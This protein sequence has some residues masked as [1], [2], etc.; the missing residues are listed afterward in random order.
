MSNGRQSLKKLSFMRQEGRKPFA[1]SDF[2]KGPLR[3]YGMDTELDIM[4]EAKC[5]V[6]QVLLNPCI[7]QCR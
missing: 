4:V 3:L 2:I 1:H 7:D 6:R 5:K